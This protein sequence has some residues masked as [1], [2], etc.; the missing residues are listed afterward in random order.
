MN[1]GGNSSTTPVTIR[2]ECHATGW[3]PPTYQWY[4]GGNPIP[5]ACSET[6]EL[7]VSQ[8]TVYEQYYKTVEDFEYELDN[9]DGTELGNASLQVY[10]YV[11]I[12]VHVHTYVCININTCMDILHIYIYIYIYTLHIYV[13]MYIYIYVC[14]GSYIY[15]FIIIHMYVYVHIYTHF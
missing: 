3:P 10:I 9:M 11:Y 15:I 2:L 13:Y 1:I 6:L 7:V 8:E 4:K 5:N 12:C 14:I